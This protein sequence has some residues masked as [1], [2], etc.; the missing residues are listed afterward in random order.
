MATETTT[1][2]TEEIA[3]ALLRNPTVALV[4]ALR[5]RLKDIV[6]PWSHDTS[7]PPKHERRTAAGELLAVVDPFLGGYGDAHRPENH[8]FGYATVRMGAST[9]GIITVASLGTEFATVEDSRAAM[10]N[11]AKGRIDD[12]LRREFMALK[13]LG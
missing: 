10:L 7:S 3:A 2:P 5:D 11:V 12:F 4:T 9:N 13:L 8:G 1:D 6:L